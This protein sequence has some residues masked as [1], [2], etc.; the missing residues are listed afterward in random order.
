MALENTWGKKKNGKKFN[1]I[2]Q[3]QRKKLASASHFDFFD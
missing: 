1:R 2:K 3:N